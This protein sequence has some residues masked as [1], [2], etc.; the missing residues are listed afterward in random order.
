MTKQIIEKAMERV[1]RFAVNPERWLEHMLCMA[2]KNSR[3]YDRD[4]YTAIAVF[5]RKG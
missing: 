3:G 1:L 2:K 5:M 4:N